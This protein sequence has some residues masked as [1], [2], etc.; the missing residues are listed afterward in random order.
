MNAI[1]KTI[2]QNLFFRNI[3]VTLENSFTKSNV[4]V[5]TYLNLYA[6]IYI[7]IYVQSKFL[8]TQH[9]EIAT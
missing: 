4:K 5:R 8:P 1:K 6:Y 2:N 3:S 7:N 9:N